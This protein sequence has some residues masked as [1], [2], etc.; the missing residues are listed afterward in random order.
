M[1]KILFSTLLLSSSFVWAQHTTSKNKVDSR[2]VEIEVAIQNGQIDLLTNVTYAQIISQRS[3]KALKMTILMPRN[4]KLKPAIIYF[5]GGGFI[6]ADY[7]KFYE[8]KNA[9]V[10]AGFVVAAAEYRVVPDLFPALVNDGKAAIRYIKAHAKELGID[11]DRIG[12]LGDS[13]G[14][15]LAQMMG[16]TNG[17]KDFDIVI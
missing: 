10:E 11:P 13:A 14:G 3:I 5:P 4:N 7:D 8:M 17:E 1:K 2:K 15:Y 6:S 12:V 16:T 9:L